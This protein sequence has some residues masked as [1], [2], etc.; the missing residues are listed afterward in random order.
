VSR[1][2][3]AIDVWENLSAYI[4]VAKDAD[5]PVCARG[6]YEL[7]GRP[8]ASHAVS[9]CGQDAWQIIPEG[10]RAADLGA[11]SDRLG[12][13]GDVRLT[14]FLLRFNGD[15]VSFKLFPDGRA[16]IEQTKDEATARKIYA[17]YIGA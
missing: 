9:L 14:K 4:D 1:Q 15:G 12:R 7:L 2:Y 13:L 10:R 6:E 17:E 8:A 5:C 3:L 16:I 11:L